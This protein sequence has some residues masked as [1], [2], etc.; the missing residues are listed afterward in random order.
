MDTIGGYIKR[1]NYLRVLDELSINVSSRVRYQG[2]GLAAEIVTAVSTA[3]LNGIAFQLYPP[4]LTP[5]KTKYIRSILNSSYSLKADDIL[6]PDTMAYVDIYVRAVTSLLELSIPS[7]PTALYQCYK[8]QTQVGA[9][10]LTTLKWLGDAN[11]YLK[12][13]P[14]AF[15]AYK[16]LLSQGKKRQDSS[17]WAHAL[18]GLGDCAL[19]RR[20]STLALRLYRDAHDLYAGLGK[21]DS[22]ARVCR[23]IADAHRCNGDFAIA[24]SMYE[25]AH[26]RAIQ[27]RNQWHEAKTLQEWAWN[28]WCIGE[29]LKASRQFER[30]LSI[31]DA[32][33]RTR[34]SSTCR[35]ALTRLAQGKALDTRALRPT[36]AEFVISRQVGYAPWIE[37]RGHLAQ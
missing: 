14:A 4:S 1:L 25:D 6:T 33:G 19:K 11:F 21:A 15:Q 27:V 18:R 36:T 13:Y 23:N 9:N 28:S 32:I 7:L 30:A 35:F 2:T 16:A 17:L 20:N 22:L 5:T 31:Y 12:R 29:K 10:S 3:K 34:G 26:Q 8:V 24:D 37:R